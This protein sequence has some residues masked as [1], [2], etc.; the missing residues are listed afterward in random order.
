M[1]K[2]P[3]RQ[4]S[5]F[6]SSTFWENSFMPVFYSIKPW[7]PG[8]DTAGCM[9]LV[10]SPFTSQVSFTCSKKVNRSDLET[11][12]LEKLPVPPL[13]PPAL[14]RFLINII[15]FV[16]LFSQGI[17]SQPARPPRAWCCSPHLLHCFA[18]HRGSTSPKVPPRAPWAS[19]PWPASPPAL[20]A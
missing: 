11:I 13:L 9:A 8:E 2:F 16:C 17:G 12:R 5:H 14:G 15:I 20:P 1:F 3:R 7:I 6:L 10:S 19:H 4:L 18:V